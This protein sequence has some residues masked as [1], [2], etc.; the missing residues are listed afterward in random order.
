M[1]PLPQS[2]AAMTTDT[3]RDNN[4][5]ESDD[6]FYELNFTQV[7]DDGAVDVKPCT[8][9][10]MTWWKVRMGNDDSIDIASDS[11][12]ASLRFETDIIGPND[13]TAAFTAFDS[14]TTDIII[15]VDEVQKLLKFF[16]YV[17]KPVPKKMIKAITSAIDDFNENSNYGHAQ[18]FSIKN[19]GISESY[20]RFKASTFLEGIKVGKTNSVEVF[21]NSA[22]LQCTILYMVICSDSV[23]KNWIIN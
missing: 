11:N 17:P 6:E 5:L 9:A 12:S 13:D 14:I 3:T 18:L 20:V 2:N 15:E 23:V 22:Q 7:S 4:G 19:E 16:S 21:V 10:L 8:Y 1:Y